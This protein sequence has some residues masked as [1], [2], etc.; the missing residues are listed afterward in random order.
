MSDSLQ[1]IIVG[2]GISGLYAAYRLQQSDDTCSIRIIE[3][4]P[5]I[6][7]RI[8]TEKYGGHIMEYGPMRFEPELQKTFARLIN[9]LNLPTKVFSPYSSDAMPD[10][11][12]LDLEEIQ[13]IKKYSKLSPVFA[14]LK[15]GLAKVLEDQWNVEDDEMKRPGRDAKKVR[16]ALSLC[17]QL[18]QSSRNGSSGTELFR[19]DTCTTTDYGILSLTCSARRLWTSCR[20]KVLSHLAKDPS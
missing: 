2:A 11:N 13:A 16:F 4:L 10:F 1:Y 17:I 7:G 9:E 3:K 19:G 6:G 18:S 12:K 5:R 14:L 8:L 20:P 15:H